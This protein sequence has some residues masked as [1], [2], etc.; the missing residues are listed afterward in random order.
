MKVISECPFVIQRGIVCILYDFFQNST[1]C[2]NTL[3]G[4]C[5]RACAECLFPLEYQTT[6]Q[7]VVG[8]AARSQGT[9]FL[10]RLSFPSTNV[11]TESLPPALL[12]M[13]KYLY[14]RSSL[15]K[16]PFF[17]PNLNKACSSDFL[18]QL[19]L[20][21]QFPSNSVT[22]LSPVQETRNS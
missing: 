8:M 2:L 4:L 17:V 1:I 22:D 15:W 13:M 20:S 9:S 21:K 10:G 14:L 6:H 7:G 3:S 19:K 18:L 11:R 16:L 12:R 5:F